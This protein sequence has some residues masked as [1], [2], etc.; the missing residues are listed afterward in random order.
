MVNVIV[1]P[2]LAVAVFL[3]LLEQANAHAVK[4]ADAQFAR[5]LVTH[6]LRDPLAHLFRG[7]VGEG[8][9]QDSTRIDAALDHFGRSMGN[10]ARLA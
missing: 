1:I 6:E 3:E 5:G 7:L 4:R 10:D 8:Y 2:A 9:E